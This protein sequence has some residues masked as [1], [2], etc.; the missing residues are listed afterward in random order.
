MFPKIHERDLRISKR[1]TITTTHAASFLPAKKHE[2]PAP[3]PA[4]SAAQPMKKTAYTVTSLFFPLPPSSTFGERIFF[5]RRSFLTVRHCASVG[6]LH[7]HVVLSMCLSTHQPSCRPPASPTPRTR[8][9]R[10]VQPQLPAPDP[11]YAFRYMINTKIWLGATHSPEANALRQDAIICSRECRRRETRAPRLPPF[12]PS[13]SVP[14]ISSSA[15]DWEG[16][17]RRSLARRPRLPSP[18]RLPVSSCTRERQR[19][20]ETKRQKGSKG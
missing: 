7:M 16:K 2:R 9:S 11:E 6:H 5:L 13:G 17:T 8:N 19:D 14:S 15:A 20:K 4:P 12:P 3:F 18:P 10:L 1:L